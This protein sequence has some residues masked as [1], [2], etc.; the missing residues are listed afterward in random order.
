MDLDFTIQECIK[1]AQ[2]FSLVPIA[3]KILFIFPL[4]IKRLLHFTSISNG[5]P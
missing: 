5:V 1:N 4:K 2:M 3:V